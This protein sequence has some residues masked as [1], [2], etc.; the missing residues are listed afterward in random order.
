MF[1][2]QQEGRIDFN[3]RKY[4]KDIW[5]PE[6]KYELKESNQPTFKFI[7]IT[8]NVFLSNKKFGDK[9]FLTKSN[10][11]VEMKYATFMKNSYF[12]FGD[13]IKSKNDFFT[14]PFASSRID[15]Y[16]SNGEKDHPK[17][18]HFNE[19]KTKLVCFSHK[20]NLVFM[21]LLHSVDEC[22]DFFSK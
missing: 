11:I 18:Y 20:E 13:R 8:P 19:I 16:I 3:L 6:L 7:R 10:E 12:I 5:V 21:P 14:S 4:A 2:D 22:C 9:W 15:I 1:L 17:M